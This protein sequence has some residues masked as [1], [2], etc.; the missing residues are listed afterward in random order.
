MTDKI[1]EILNKYAMD[2]FFDTKFGYPVISVDNFEAIAQET[3][4]LFDW[5]EIKEWCDLPDECE[6]VLLL[7]GD[8]HEKAIGYLD[9]DTIDNVKYWSIDGIHVHLNVF[10][11]WKPITL[12]KEN[13]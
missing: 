5:I 7:V 3:D 4:D 1:K 6:D 13:K 10:S 2:S 12:P 8:N 11:H 9:E